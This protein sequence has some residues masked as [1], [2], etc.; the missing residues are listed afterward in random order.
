[1]KISN[2]PGYSDVIEI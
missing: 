2:Q 1:M